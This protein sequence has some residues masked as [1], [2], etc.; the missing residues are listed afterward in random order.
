MMIVVALATM[1]CATGMTPYTQNAGNNGAILGGAIGAI[2][3][4]LLKGGRGAAYGA[5]AGAAIGSVG[6]VMIGEQQEG[7]PVGASQGRIGGDYYGGGYQIRRVR[8]NCSDPQSWQ[9]INYCRGVM[10]EQREI[11]R[12]RER[13]RR[14]REYQLEEAGRRSVRYGW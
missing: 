10:R 5:A 12:E 3:G 7:F 2:A 8:V 11:E 13:Y 1:G 9:E 14:D 6:G 4:G